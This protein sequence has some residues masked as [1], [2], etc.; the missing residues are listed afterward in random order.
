MWTTPA[1]TEMR[2]GF[3]VTMYVMKK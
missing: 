1:V 2:F 3:E